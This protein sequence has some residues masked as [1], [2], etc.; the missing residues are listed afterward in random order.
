[1]VTWLNESNNLDDLKTNDIATTIE[2]HT[3]YTIE[4]GHVVNNIFSV[5][6]ASLGTL[7]AK[8]WSY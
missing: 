2:G 1:M 4:N 8:Y 6:Q 7:N 5:S 3:Y